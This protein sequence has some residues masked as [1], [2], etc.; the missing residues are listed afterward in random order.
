MRGRPKAD[1]VLTE[2][3]RDE[4]RA[5]ALRRKSAQAMAL[6]ARIVLACADGQTNLDVAARLSVTKQTVS[7][8]RGRFVKV[9]RP[10]F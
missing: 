6:R 8:W 1:L 7:K 9:N 3:E 5:L 2:T 4:L 10:G